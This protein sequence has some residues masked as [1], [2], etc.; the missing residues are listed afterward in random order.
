MGPE[1]VRSQ[2]CT[3]S[4]E[5]ALARFAG[6]V[7]EIESPMGFYIESPVAVLPVAAQRQEHCLNVCGPV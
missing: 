4:V 7:K 3:C 5:N 1:P 6:Q 2:T